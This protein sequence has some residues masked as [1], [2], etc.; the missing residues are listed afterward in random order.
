M[1]LRWPTLLLLA[2]CAQEYAIGS[3][4]DDPGD[5]VDSDPVVEIG[6]PDIEVDK[7]ELRFGAAL[8]DCPAPEQVFTVTNVGD[9]DLVIKEF[10]L[11][12]PDQAVYEVL[13]NPKT[14]KPAASMDVA[15]GFTPLDIR[16]YGDALVEIASNDPDEPTVRVE[17]E[18]SGDEVA[19]R[20][21]V[22]E[23]G[24]GGAVDVLFSIDYS[25]SMSSEIAALGSKFR[26]FIQSFQNLGLDYQIAVITAD[27][28]CAEFRGSEKVITPQTADPEAAFLDA[29]SGASC[30]G[31]AAFGASK[32]ALTAPLINGPNK[33]FLRTDA[34]LAIVALSDEPEQSGLSPQQYVNWLASLKGGDMN[35]VSFSGV[36]GPDGSG[37]FPVCR[38]EV[39]RAPQYH[40]AIRLSR[41]VWGDICNLDL[42]PFLT[43][44]SYVA[45]GLDFAFELTETPTAFTPG[46]ITVTVDGVPVPYGILNGWTYDQATNSVQLHGSAIP[47]PGA[48]IVITYPYDG[49]C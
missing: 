36:V 13:D 20:E 25:G 17:L 23:Q 33:D 49:G 6:Q 44:L 5:P 9:A 38:G 7:K 34:N 1:T 39:E 12:G 8:P 16:K 32:A 21:E 18:G 19:Y 47:D 48:S 46:A 26:T 31:E 15:V 24:E 28:T 14:L 2:G 40:Q 42:V 29:T 27:E 4:D 30:G 11:R 22:F 3:K 10:K 43:H 35:K 37:I 41:G 45:A